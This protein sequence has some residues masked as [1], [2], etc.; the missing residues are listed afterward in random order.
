[1]HELLERLRVPPEV[2]LY[3]LRDD[4]WMF[5]LEGFEIP[6]TLLMLFDGVFWWFDLTSRDEDML[7][8]SSFHVLASCRG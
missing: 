6:R 8:I 4:I 5:E 2:I 1:M 7:G 3:W